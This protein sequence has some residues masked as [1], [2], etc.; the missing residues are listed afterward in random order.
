[1]PVVYRPCSCHAPHYAGTRGFSAPAKY[2][3]PPLAAETNAAVISTTL[4]LLKRLDPKSWWYHIER[5]LPAYLKHPDSDVRHA[6][7]EAAEA[8]K[9]C[10]ASLAAVPTMGPR[11]TSCSLG[12]ACPGPKPPTKDVD[13]GQVDDRS[14]GVRDQLAGLSTSGQ[15]GA[16]AGRQPCGQCGGDHEKL[17]ACGGC[18]VM[19]YCSAECQKAHWKQHR[20]ECKRVQRERSS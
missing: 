1:M 18:R 2:A 15:Q 20:A 16:R 10:D 8:S 17:L 11:A 14:A 3:A 13:V 12:G 6:A 19:G 9:A 4:Q 5:L 7:E